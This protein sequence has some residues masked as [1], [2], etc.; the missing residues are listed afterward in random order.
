MSE[1]PIPW[2]VTLL[3]GLAALATWRAPRLPN[4]ARAFL[5]AG[6]AALAVLGLVLGLRVTFD[7]EWSLLAQPLIAL[8][9]GSLIYL[10]LEAMS[11]EAPYPWRRALLWHGVPISACLIAIVLSD[12]VL[13][14]LLIPLIML[15]YLALLVRLA[16]QPADV[17]I[18]ATPATAKRVRVGLLIVAAIY[19][20]FLAVDITIQIA[21]VLAGPE[22]LPGLITVATQVLSLVTVL[23]A[24]LAIIAVYA[25]PEVV[26]S[27][28]TTAEQKPNA[29]DHETLAAFAAMLDD[30]RLYT[31][32]SLT[33]ARAARR[34]GLPARALSRAVN[35]AGQANLSRYINGF[36]IRY[37][38][39]LLRDTDLPVTEVMLDAGFV[40]KSTFNA[41]FR[42]IEGTTPSAYRA[43]RA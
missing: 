9:T 25:R 24:A 13:A 22:A 39:Q 30:T 20:L 7:V 18:H 14:D 37:A 16:W 17:F 5:T 26:P 3:A 43:N 10:G 28:E 35:R 12:R 15:T 29:D 34:M 36:R 41:E 32:P 40:S 27:V 38:A 6:L 42:R 23:M 19:F 1:I 21:I 4:A 8:V 33:L 2:V 11:V 31:D